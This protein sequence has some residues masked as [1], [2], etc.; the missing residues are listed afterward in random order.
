MSF[1][2]PPELP[3]CL[4]VANQS[5]FFAV[6][7]VYCVGRNYAEHAREMGADPVREPPFFFCKPNDKE[8]ILPVLPNQTTPLP[9]PSKT[10]N[11]HYEVELVVAIG[12]DGV[13]IQAENAVE[14][15]FGYAIGLDMTRRD[16]QNRFKQNA[17]PWDMAKAFDYSAPIGM[18]HPIQQ[19]GEI[20]QGNISLDVNGVLQ[21][22]GDISQ[23]IWTVNEVIANLSEFVALK[24]GD[25]IFTGTPAGVGSVFR[26]DVIT[27]CIDNLGK[28][29]VVIR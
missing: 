22:Q 2:Y 14:H 10:Q 17:H 13:N 20:Y 28:I 9:Y 3:A 7:R 27:A 8:A 6:R 4:P 26:G 29:S 23:L 11:L 21:Q 25:L 16:L 18:L 15:I 12:K 24:A 19:V 1:I 5:A